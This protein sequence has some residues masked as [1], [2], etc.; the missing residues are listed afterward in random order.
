MIKQFLYSFTCLC[1]C[2]IIG[3]AVYE[4][5]AVVPKWSA[6]PPESLSMFQGKYGLNPGVFWMLIHPVTLLLFLV[7]II[8]NWRSRSMK[9]LMF[10]F[11]GYLAV[12]AVTASYF[13]PELMEITNTPYAISVD[14]NLVERAKMWELLSIV[15]LGF[16]T[17]LAMVMFM[18]FTKTATVALPKKERKVSAMVE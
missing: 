9:N 13:V 8:F 14:A 6:A 11:V 18:G 3:G 1:F 16:I 12:L 5:L 15:R 7:T 2:I 17:I 10:S 4:H